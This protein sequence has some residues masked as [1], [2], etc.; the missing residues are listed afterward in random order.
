MKKNPFFISCLFLLLL[1]CSNEIPETDKIQNT[2]LT[3]PVTL[4]KQ[5]QLPVF[6]R[7]IGTVMSDK[8]VD[9]TS[10]ITGFITEI[11]I[12]E[13]QKVEKGQVLVMLDNS[14]IEGGIQQT[15][16]AK[17]KA[18]A[19]LQDALTDFKRYQQLFKRGSVS[20]NNL[21][22]VTLSKEI[23]ESALREAKAALKTAESQRQYSRITSPVDGIVVVRQKRKGDL[24][25]PGAS[26]VT[27][28]SDS[29]LL[30]ESYVPESQIGHVKAGQT[31]EVNIDALKQKLNATVLRVVHSGDPISRR[32][33]I[34]VEL[35]ETSRLLSGM[36][37]YALFPVGFEQS[38]T[39]PRSARV[40]RGGLEG[41]FVLDK[42][43]HAHFR[44][45][46]L[47]R[48]WSDKIQVHAGLKGGERIVAVADK[49]I[50]EGDQIQAL[51]SQQ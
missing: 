5:E 3:L 11:L 19:S 7:A 21:R 40:N 12:K 50:R 29:N 35:P 41:V 17:N 30:F 24:A 20:E 37:G 34:K 13:G 15:I 47:G 14:D 10:R 42:Q 46:R 32:Y 18:Q 26:I 33:Q 25:T 31:V 16:A 27:I 43:N 8:R 45:L 38:P 22:K 28:E 9:I 39:I 36:Y 48:E 49:K 44:W 51:E 23:A 1:G 2:P 6:Y 4:V